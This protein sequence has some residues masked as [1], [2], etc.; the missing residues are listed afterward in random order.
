MTTLDERLPDPIERGEARAEG[1]AD[2]MIRG[3][4]FTCDCG[5]TIPL[6]EAISISLDPYAAPGCYECAV[7]VFGEGFDER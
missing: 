3:N 1:W 6:D 5:E 2:E 4:E 7:S